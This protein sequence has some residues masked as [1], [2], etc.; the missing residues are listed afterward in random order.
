MQFLQQDQARAAL[1]RLGDAGLDH[2]QVGIRIA[3]VALLDQAT[4]RVVFFMAGAA[5]W[6]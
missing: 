2:R 6:M 1:G 4:G 3:V 5:P